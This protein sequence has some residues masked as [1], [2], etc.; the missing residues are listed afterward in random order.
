KNGVYWCACT[1]STRSPRK[2]WAKRRAQFQSRPDV[3][4]IA[5]T[6]NPSSCNSRPNVPNSSR[7]ANT[8]RNAG[9]SP[10][11]NPTARNSA[12]PTRRLCKT[13]QMVTRRVAKLCEPD[14][15][16]VFK[17]GE[18]AANSE[19]SPTSGGPAQG[20]AEFLAARRPAAFAARILRA[21]RSRNFVQAEAAA[22]PR[23][24]GSGSRA[25]PLSAPRRAHESLTGIRTGEDRSSRDRQSPHPDVAILNVKA[26]RHRQ[27]PAGAHWLS[28]YPGPPKSPW[29]IPAF[30]GGRSKETHCQASTPRSAVG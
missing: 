1:R 16:A 10:W 22:R 4:S 19:D 3:R 9:R 25:D 23:T 2:N 27:P 14:F 17:A 20:R 18:V 13:W 30:P 7:Q 6:E 26:R 8:V 12:P 15:K 21:G 24:L 11:A 28:G 5:K 29:E